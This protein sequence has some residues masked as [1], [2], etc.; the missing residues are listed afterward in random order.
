[1]KTR[2]IARPARPGQ[3]IFFLVCAV[4]SVLLNGASGGAQE[5]PPATPTAAQTVSAPAEARNFAAQGTLPPAAVP[6]KKADT[7]T[8]GQR[9]LQPGD[10]GAAV[11]REDNPGQRERWFYEQRAY[12]LGYI[13]FGIRQRAVEARDA[14]RARERRLGIGSFAPRARTAAPEAADAPVGSQTIP[15]STTQ[16]TFIGPQPVTSTSGTIKQVSGRTSAIA[17]DPANPQIVYVGGAQGGVWKSTDGGATWAAISD[18]EA[19]LAIGAIAIDPTDPQIVYVGTGEQTNSIGSYYGAGILKS[20]NG[21]ASWTQL[22]QS[23][24]VGPF[25]GGFSPGGGARIS[26]LA[27]RPGTGGANAELLAGVLLLQTTG[28]GATS[29]VYRSTDGGVTWTQVLSGAAGSE[30]VFDPT[31]DPMTGRSMIAYAA[32][33]T[34]IGDPD[35]GIYKSTDGGATWTRLGGGLP[36][37]NL[38]RIELALAPSQPATLYAS[39]AD[40]S[41]SSSHLLG[42]FKSTNG[43]ANWAQVA[44]GNALLSGTASTCSAQCWYDHVIRVH[45]NHPD[46]VYLGGAATGFGAGNYF[47][48]STDGGNTWSGI[49]TDGANRLHVDIHALAFGFSGSTAVRLWNANDGG[50]W[51]A[52][53]TNPLDPII[54]NNHNGPAGGSATA[55]GTLQYYPGHSIHPGNPDFTIGGTQDNGTHI[56]TGSLG[57]SEVPVCGDGGYTAI[58]PSVPTTIYAACQNIAINKSLNSGTSW[59]SANGNI[60]TSDSSAFIPPLI[61]DLNANVAPFTRRQL[62]FGTFRVWRGDSDPNSTAAPNWTA[63][64]QDLNNGSSVRALAVS[65]HDSRIVWAGTAVGSIHRTLD[66]TQFDN[67]QNVTGS[68]MLPNRTVTALAISPH[69]TSSNT[70]YATFSGFTF[71]SD[72]RGHVFVTTNGGAAWTDISANLPNTPVNDIVVDPDVNGTLF[73]ATDVGVF[74]SSNGG[75]SWTT[76]DPAPTQSLPTVAVLGLKLH[77][78][79]RLLRAGTHGRG[80]WD[81]TLSNFNPTFN[82]ASMSPTS[83]SAGDADTQITVTGVGFS[84]TSVVR[85]NT[86]NLATNT[87]G[88]PTQLTAT[89]PAA[90]LA[91]GQTAQIDVFDPAQPAPS[92]TNGLPFSVTNPTPTLTSI[93]PNTAAPGGPGFTLTLNGTNFIGTLGGT[94]AS[95]VHWN[96]SP[97]TTNATLVSNQQITVDIPASDIASPGLNQV[98]V[99][100]PSP[101]G[102]TTAPQ[103]FTVGTPPPNDNFANA[104]VINANPFSDSQSVV[105]ASTEANDPLPQPTLPDCPAGSGFPSPQIG[106]NYSIWYRFT[107][108][109]NLAANVDT[110]GSNYDTVLSVWTGPALGALTQVACDDDGVAGFGPSRLTGLMLT[111]GT[112]YHFMVGGFSSLDAGTA[113]FNF[114][115]PPDF[116]VG[117]NP[118][119]VTV[120]RGQASQA[121]TVTV[122]PLN[123]IAFTNPVALSCTG[124]PSQS[125][126]VFNPTSVTPGANPATATLTITTTAP[127]MGPPAGPQGVRWSPPPVAV[128]ALLLM[129]ALLFAVALSARAARRAPAWQQACFL[130]A[131]VI[132]A[133]VVVSCGG[134]G[135]G[136]GGPAPPPP[137]PGTPTGTFNVTVRGVSGGITKTAT[138][139]LTVQ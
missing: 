65:P 45:P 46:V 26:S 28:G 29:G 59:S 117:V 55:L 94:P 122:T 129:V 64:S 76:L 50:V 13:P 128:L 131:I 70:V 12:P 80:M 43:G 98:T 66:A 83:A 67:W 114:T 47:I 139:A 56:Y 14:M 41:G 136:G 105:V 130:L 116:S 57:W 48:R 97:R 15:P 85:F 54:W 78:P 34:F 53:V 17:V 100:N 107:P 7:A 52:D 101:G 40:A 30:V 91:T 4:A 96:G 75:A 125:T 1:M 102:G 31:L 20:T 58:D 49:A 5:R 119:A 23:T 135:G 134:G 79:T 3:G 24:F 27:I 137:N 71:G 62:Y 126:C 115:I 124:L 19:S 89:I 63:I 84:A 103:T 10:E 32:L 108:T 93:S 110:A 127:G 104:I 38:G 16:W 61:L 21:G 99:F 77:R 81:L 88:A 33:G 35:N 74:M 86:T 109:V 11:F 82:L 118:A 73:V 111:A 123:G 133:G 112:T 22:G 69:D 95:Q 44:V 92:T 120:T 51:S 138:V 106:R 72:T 18:F 68:G 36:T 39:I 90:L 9:V 8:L 42:V 60:A 87:S 37:S 121:I 25:S 6:K 113:V 132:L 2:R